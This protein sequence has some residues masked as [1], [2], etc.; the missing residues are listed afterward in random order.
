MVACFEDSHGVWTGAHF[1]I[2]PHFGICYF[3]AMLPFYYRMVRFVP[4]VGTPGAMETLPVRPV[5]DRTAGGNTQVE[6]N[7][8]L[9]PGKPE[10]QSAAKPISASPDQFSESSKTIP[11]TSPGTFHLDPIWGDSAPALPVFPKSI[12]IASDGT[13]VSE[14]A[15]EAGNFLAAQFHSRHEVC[16]FLAGDPVAAAKRILDRA[17]E[18]KASLLILGTHGRKGKDRVTAGSVAEVVLKEAACPVL[19]VPKAWD[20]EKIHRILVPIDASL[21]AYPEIVG[22]MQL[23]HYF[24]AE[25]WALHLFAQ[26]KEVPNNIQKMALTMGAFKWNLLE[27]REGAF[28]KEMAE[29]IVE[30][31]QGHSIDLILMATHSEMIH[32]QILPSSVCLEVLRQTSCP[33]WVVHIP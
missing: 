4:P 33:L 25:L 20:C 23:A 10:A 8:Y 17:K 6:S 13:P 29:T 19:I 14:P 27:E 16:Q 2:S 12:L 15:I 24:G 22:G 21:A 30:F 9:L 1:R 28:Q 18:T 26:G 31:T 11:V 3:E 5:A 32:G 7:Q